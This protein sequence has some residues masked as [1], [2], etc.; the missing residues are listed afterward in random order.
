MAAA[1]LVVFA[2]S[3]ATAD[4]TEQLS[5][6]NPIRKVVNLLDNLRKSVEAEAKS[7]EQLFEKYMCYCKNGVGDLE[8]SIDD[9]ETKITELESS[10]KSDVAKKKQLDEDLKA[11]KADRAAAKKAVAEATALREKEAQAYAAYSADAKTNIAAVAKAVAALKAGM[12]GSA[13]LQTLQGSTGQAL[14]SIVLNRD[15][16][17]VTRQTLMAFLQGESNSNYAPQSGEIVGM[18]ATMGDEMSADLKDATAAE[19]AAIKSFKELVAAKTKEIAALTKAIEEKTER[20]GELAVSL[21]GRQNEIEDTKESLA[22]DKKFLAD[23][24]KGCGTKEAEYAEIVKT[25]N[26]E[27]LALADTIKLMNDDDALEL[28][29]KTLPSASSSFLQTQVSAKAM[30][31]RA[32]D[33]LHAAQ[34]KYGPMARLDF[35]ELALRG[36]GGF[37]KIVKMI[38]D[39]MATLKTEQ[40]DDDKKKEWCDEEFDVSD[41]KKKEIEGTITDLNTAIEAEQQAIAA[42]TDEI[43]ALSDSIEALDK[44]VAEATEQRKEENA[45]YKKSMAENGA[46]KELILLAKNRMNKFYNP[47]LYK[48]PPKRDLSE[49]DRITVNMGG[50]LAATAAPG[51]IAG[52]GISALQAAPPPP[53]EAPSYSKKS[54]ESNGVIAMMD[55]LVKD[56]DKDMTVSSAEEKDAQ[57]AYEKAMQDAADK[58]AADSKSLADKKAAK[59]DTTEALE[60]HKEEKASSAKELGATLQYIHSL[61]GDCDWLVKYFTQRK[62]ARANEVNSLSNAKAVLAGADYSLLQAAKISKHLRA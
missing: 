48:A 3:C 7:D 15:M 9:A 56:L 5:A 14:R 61:H 50:T 51:G 32:L 10:I 59:A 18:L 19:D 47:A 30:K 16:A 58:R 1:F 26:E 35:I 20:S 54:E 42:L 23:L 21:A 25:R 62:E 60:Q 33:A 2:L 24:K 27:L 34:Q 22:D 12:G 45:A 28:F 44:Q 46:A 36:K 37:D 4:A 6:A 57:A 55:I 41:D 11:H 29:K 31:S 8:K 38:V 53:P 43:K 40:E 17:D 39:L 49:E 13:L 52:T